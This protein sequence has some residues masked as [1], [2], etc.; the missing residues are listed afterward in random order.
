MPKRIF[1]P[2]AKKRSIIVRDANPSAKAVRK[3]RKYGWDERRLKKQP[4]ILITDILGKQHIHHSQ[5]KCLS[6][7][8]LVPRFI[9]RRASKILDNLSPERRARAIENVMRMIEGA[10]LRKQRTDR[11]MVAYRATVRRIAVK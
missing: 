5:A 8:K 3:G 10:Y 9:M 11:E 2:V 1:N 4:G 7:E 6:G